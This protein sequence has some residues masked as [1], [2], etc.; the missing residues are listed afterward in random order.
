MV[1]KHEP[2]VWLWEAIQKVYF[3]INRR[4]MHPLIYKHRLKDQLKK[5]DKLNLGAGGYLLKGW[6]NVSLYSEIGLPY[7]VARIRKGALVLNF[8]LREE[9]PISEASLKYIYGSSFIEHLTFREAITV[10]E[11][12]FRYLRKGGVIRLTF[13]DLELWVRNYH[14][15]NLPFFNKY[16]SIYLGREKA[17]V[18][19]K[20]EIF[21]SQVHGW[22]H[23]WG[24]DFESMRHLLEKAGFSQVAKKKAFTSLIPMIKAIEPKGEGRLLGTTYVEAVKK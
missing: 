3:F 15:N 7:G 1:K 18:K 21:M 14:K 13:P 10:L 6:L 22:G 11:K 19:T 8:D 2:L 17:I 20:G 23:R 12:C 24:Y 4:L 5:I 9:L 16:Q